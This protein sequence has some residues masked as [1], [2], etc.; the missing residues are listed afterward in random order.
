M[1]LFILPCAIL[2]LLCTV[3]PVFSQS[4]IKVREIDQNNKPY[5]DK[6]NADINSRLTVLFD[7]ATFIRKVNSAGI[8]N[9]LP[10]DAVSLL[11]TLYD[12]TQ[13]VEGWSKGMEDAVKNYVRGDKA[14]LNTFLQRTSAITAEIVAIFDRDQQTRDYYESFFN[15]NE[16]FT[17][18]KMWSGILFAINKRMADLE[19]QLS[20]TPVYNDVRI[21]IGGWLMH[22]NQPS[23]LH[24][25]GLDEN[26]LGDYYEVERWKFTLTDA[27]LAQLEDIQKWVKSSQQR[28]LNVNEILRGE[29]VR[30]FTDILQQRLKTD[31]E[32]FRKEGEKVLTTLQDQQIVT[33][34]KQIL[35]QG[36][37]IKTQLTEKVNYYQSLLNNTVPG[38]SIAFISKLQNDVN[39]INGEFNKMKGL[40]TDFQSHIPAATAEVRTQC[41]N[42]VT[43][44]SG[45]ITALAN[46]LIPDEI[47]RFGQA[48]RRL[49]GLALSFSDK[50][51]SLALGDIPSEATTDLLYSGFR[52]EGDRVVI[53]MVVTNTSTKKSLLEESHSVTLYRILPHLQATVGVIFAHPL[54]PTKIEKDV[55]MAPYYNVLFKGIFGMSQKWKRNSSL[56]NNLLDLNFG[57]HVSSP[58][59]DKDDVPELGLGVVASALKDYLQVGWAYNLFQ[60]AN[61][62]F[63]GF[64]LPIPTMNLGGGNNSSVPVK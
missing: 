19:E 53:K 41:A 3:R 4:I 28:E 10:P 35:A 2:F 15:V 6:N 21:Q 31:F 52:Q 33:D 5:D 44:A 29:Y 47:L 32:D 37:L 64:R 57:L 13:K 34:V 17:E 36:D 8:G 59:F 11:N 60:G 45:K 62:V 61:Y 1:R 54:T 56:P 14:S 12:A 42:L 39:A 49:E 48:Q 40:L 18:E 23:P 38:N 9:P 63:I 25:N 43:M 58:D 22:N 51:Y 50:V 24:F 46:L 26:P 16:D 27:Q 55:Q 30:Q 7:R 20:K